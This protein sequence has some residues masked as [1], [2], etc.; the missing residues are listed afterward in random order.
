MQTNGDGRYVDLQVFKQLA[1]YEQR[2]LL[3]N[4]KARSQLAQSDRMYWFKLR[5]KRYLGYRRNEAVGQWRARVQRGTRYTY[6]NIGFADEGPSRTDQQHFSF[7]E[8]IAVVTRFANDPQSMRRRRTTETYPAF[9][10]IA[11]PIGTE[12]SVLKA[13][14]LYLASLD[15]RAAR[16]HLANLYRIVNRHIVPELGNTH[17]DDLT[18]PQIRHWFEN[19]DIRPMTWSR[20]LIRQPGGPRFSEDETEENLCK[21]TANRAMTTLRSVLNFAWHEG[22]ISGYARPWVRV[23]TYKV[24]KPKVAQGLSR[25]ECGKLVKS[26]PVDLRSLVLAA[27]FTGARLSELR[28][29]KRADFD[30]Y[31]GTLFVYSTKV[32]RARHIVL[33]FEALDFFEHLS[34]GRQRDDFLLRKQDGEP[35]G[36]GE[37]V[38]MFRQACLAAGIERRVV[39]HELRHTYASHQIMAGVSPF[40][41]ADQLGHRDC[42]QLFRTYG[43]VSTSFSEQQIRSLTPNY[44]LNN[45]DLEEIAERHAFIVDYRRAPKGSMPIHVWLGQVADW[46]KPVM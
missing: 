12:L 42:S 9:H 18:V 1:P 46:S 19:L 13:S 40:V 7:R 3:V 29:L 34:S 36:T 38:H 43:H 33:S 2:A 14:I 45:P 8:A 25:E 10:L 37:H 20:T 5:D 31:S 39:F 17:C 4:A 28:A 24:S 26:C 22:L 23:R 15:G 11:S 41:I 32:R 35:W 44:V 27:L 16:D 21:E 6:L 30:Y